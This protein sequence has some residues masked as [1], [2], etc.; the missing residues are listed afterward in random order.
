MAELL[1]LGTG[2]SFNDGSREPT[3]LALRGPRSTIVIDCGAN[4]LRQ[5]QQLR[6]PLDSIESLVLTHSHPDHTSG[7]ALFIEMLW[8]SGR[9]H[10]LPVYGPQDAVDVAR[11]AFAQ[12]DTS[13]WT[14]LPRLDWQAVPLAPGTPVYSGADFELVSSPGI[15]SVPVICLRARDRNGGGV[16]AF[17]ADG[18]PSPG[19]R[20][21]AQGAGLLVHEATGTGGGHS[22]AEDAARLAREAGAGKLILVHLAPQAHDLQQQQRV[23]AAIF[24]GEVIIGRDLDRFTF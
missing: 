18:E 2:A 17:S 22:S 3:M 8:L 20:D 11:R 13:S 16:V 24:G 19:V 7:M 5:L 15:H 21:L 9:R 12:W 4:P 23:A 1:L 10:P 14:G 6:V